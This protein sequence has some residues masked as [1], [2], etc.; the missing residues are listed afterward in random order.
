MNI[1][2]FN[3][4]SFTDHQYFREESYNI[5]S[6]DDLMI[7][8]NSIAGNWNTNIVSKTIAELAHLDRLADQKKCKVHAFIFLSE[9]LRSP[10][11]I[12]ILRKLAKT[13]G[14]SQGL[15]FC[16]SE[17]AKFYYNAILYKVNQLANVTVHISTAFTDLPITTRL[18]PMY[19]TVCGIANTEL[20]NN[21]YTVSYP[22]IH[23]DGEFLNMGF[24]KEDSIKVINASIERC[25]LLETIPNIYKYHFNSRQ[26]YTLII[27]EIKNLL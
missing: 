8:N 21:C 12:A 27:N 1:I 16:L 17:L 23:S 7:I 26:Q 3:G 4:D 18:T 13:H 20:T 11:E 10:T 9:L 25:K 24:T 14:T 19:K 6:S 22:A 15:E 5:L 2:Y